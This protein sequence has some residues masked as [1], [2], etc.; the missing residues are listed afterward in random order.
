[1]NSNEQRDINA[2]L[3]AAEFD[4]IEARTRRNVTIVMIVV[5]FVF[6][7]Y[8]MSS[9][10][11]TGLVIA[12]TKS[13]SEG[14][15]ISSCED[16]QSYQRP[17]PTDKVRC[18]ALGES[19]AWQS[20]FGFRSFGMLADSQLVE[21]C[22]SDRPAGA[23]PYPW[24]LTADQCKSWR[25]VPKSQVQLASPTPGLGGSA[26]LSWRAPALNT[27]GSPI[28][29]LL[30]T[31]ILYGAAADK[32]TQVITL[33]VANSSDQMYINSYTVTGLAPGTWYFALRAY[34]AA[35][36]ESAN[37]AVVSKTIAGSTTP[38]PIPQPPGSVTIADLP[39]FDLVKSNNKL[40]AKQIGTA[41]PQTPYLAIAAAIGTQP[42]CAVDRNPVRLASGITT[43][44]AVV[45][46]RC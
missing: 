43:K 33:P 30:G 17:L 22:D 44:P 2:E 12:C 26:A 3:E 16:A 31:R 45:F 10:A 1:M 25:M 24:S 13:V 29:V 9:R 14:A 27:D 46:V 42:Y 4:A 8:A 6:L 15:A 23:M 40:T 37:S 35:G 36:A 21:I 38:T 41:P 7:A 28:T 18:A 11:D 32:L 39:A 34:T 19:G 5:A 20:G